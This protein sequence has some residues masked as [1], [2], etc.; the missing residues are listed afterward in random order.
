M[1]KFNFCDKGSN[2]E[3]R[4]KIYKRE[5]YKF[6]GI[7]FVHDEKLNAE[8][9]YRDKRFE[10]PVKEYLESFNTQKDLSVKAIVE[11]KVE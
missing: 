2:L 7:A 10:K 4:R 9:A 1:E 5:C 11:R 3:C 6:L 8:P